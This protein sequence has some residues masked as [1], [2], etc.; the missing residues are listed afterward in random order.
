MDS[1]KLARERGLIAAREVQRELEEEQLREERWRQDK[2]DLR[3]LENLRAKA[4][5]N[6]PTR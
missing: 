6:L 3:T 2:E 1:E 4:V 5:A